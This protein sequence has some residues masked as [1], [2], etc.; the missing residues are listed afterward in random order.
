[1]TSLLAVLVGLLAAPAALAAPTVPTLSGTS[2]YQLEGSWT[3]Q[4]GEPRVLSDL[5]GK[6]VVVAMVFTHCQ[7]SC[8]QIIAN[9][10]R[11]EGALTA[12]QRTQTRF[13]L[14]SM[15]PSRDTPTVLKTFAK[16]THL[17]LRWWT[18]LRGSKD[19]VRAFSAM[20]SVRYKKAEDG[21]FAH[22]NHITLLNQA[23]EIT[24]V[25]AGLNADVKP[26]T[27]HL[28]QQLTPK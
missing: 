19:V 21:D 27:K 25:A 12:Q 28:L 10:K 7:H 13:V 4:E 1:M 11:I 3:D 17:D 2:I 20:L 23:G 26:L 15:D 5:L 24:L 14:V 18:L 6:P 16:K 8:P 9:L 22:S